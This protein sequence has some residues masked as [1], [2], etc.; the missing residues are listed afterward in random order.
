MIC[1]R[2]SAVAVD[3]QRVVAERQCL[4]YLVGDVFADVEV[5][6]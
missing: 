5:L 1:G 6:H 3:D 4:G 2:C